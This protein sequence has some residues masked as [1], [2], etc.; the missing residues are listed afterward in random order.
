MYELVDELEADLKLSADTHEAAGDKFIRE[1]M[2]LNSRDEAEQRAAKIDV[3]DIPSRHLQRQTVRAA[4]DFYQLVGKDVGVKAID[5]EG[6]RSYADD[7]KMTIGLEGGSPRA[8]RQT[9]F[10]EMGHFAEFT[11]ADSTKIASDW[12][13]KRATG[14]PK[15]LRELT[16]HDYDE[17]E[18]A[19]P[20]NFFHPYVGKEYGDGFT[21]V[22][23]MGLEE[24]S[25]GRQVAKLFKKDREHFDL[26]IRYIRK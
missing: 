9:L 21:E 3:S 18:M 5:H 26:I 13:K 6:D 17:D 23:S 2:R 25:S 10:H 20:D 7:V 16:G 19:S 14:E 22:H 4:A 1:L 24:F 12:V 15:S 11:D 8:R